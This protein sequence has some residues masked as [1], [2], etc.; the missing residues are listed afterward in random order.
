MSS[1]RAAG[2]YMSETMTP[3]YSPVSSYRQPSTGTGWA[4]TG[5]PITVWI[6]ARVGQGG[7]PVV[8]A[9]AA[10]C[11]GS[12]AEPSPQA[13]TTMAH[14]RTSD[15][16]RDLRFIMIDSVLLVDSF[17]LYR[18]FT[19]STLPSIRTPSFVWPRNVALVLVSLFLIV[20]VP[21]PLNGFMR[22]GPWSS[23]GT[24]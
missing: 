23:G 2:W 8:A 10:I 16:L 7:L 19:H 9:A 20:T 15:I 22:M 24:A 11:C 21:R 1:A 5:N 3:A 13:M 14:A 12:P 17:F 4:L 6:C 18:R